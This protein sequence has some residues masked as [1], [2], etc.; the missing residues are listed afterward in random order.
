M[1]FRPIIAGMRLAGVMNNGSTVV[2]ATASQTLALALYHSAK[3][4]IDACHIYT[5]MHVCEPKQVNQERKTESVSLKM[6]TDH[7]LTRHVTARPGSSYSRSRARTRKSSQARNGAGRKP[8]RL[9]DLRQQAICTSD[10][11][12]CDAFFQKK[13]FSR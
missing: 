7:W 11:G 2:L 12:L 1:P 8:A 3:K 5:Y 13:G 4:G 10:P 9:R 6:S